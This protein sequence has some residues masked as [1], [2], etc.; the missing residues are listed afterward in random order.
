MHPFPPQGSGIY[1]SLR[2]MNWLET[3]LQ[4]DFVSEG[5]RS[6]VR[7]TLGNLYDSWGYR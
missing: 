3:A 6:L 2:I 4:K 1:E 5:R 7:E